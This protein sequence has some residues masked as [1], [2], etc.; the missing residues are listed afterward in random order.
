MGQIRQFTAYKLNDRGKLMVRVKPHYSSQECSQCGHTE[1]GNRPSQAAFQCLGCGYA[2]NA[3]DNAACIIKK[4]GITHVRSDA[5]SIEKT[6]RTLKVRR[7]KTN[8][9]QELASSGSGDCVRPDIQAVINDALNSRQTMEHHG[10]SETRR[11]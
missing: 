8:K 5:F 11:L 1:K 4:R 6:P 2:A 10:L 3:D 9:A 7:K